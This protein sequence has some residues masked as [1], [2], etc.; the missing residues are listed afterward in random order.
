M[1]GR[2]G[3]LLVVGVVVILEAVWVSQASRVAGSAFVRVNGRFDAF[4]AVCCVE[5]LWYIPE[6]PAE[7]HA[8]RSEML[9]A[10]TG[11]AR[12]HG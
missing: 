4:L 3:Y 11:A 12:W 7:R 5:L 2:G 1:F 6:G 10:A 9:L 8:A